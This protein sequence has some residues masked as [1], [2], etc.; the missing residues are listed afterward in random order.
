MSR[1]PIDHNL[2]HEK[3]PGLLNESTGENFGLKMRARPESALPLGG[4]RVVNGEKLIDAG[5]GDQIRMITPISDLL[6]NLIAQ[7]QLKKDVLN[8]ALA[9][10]YRLTDSPEREGVSAE[11]QVAKAVS[12][13]F[14]AILALQLSRGNAEE[15][16]GMLK[17]FST[18]SQN[19]ALGSDLQHLAPEVIKYLK[20]RGK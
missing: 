19:G 18:F 10:A 7:G 14:L 9:D 11:T 13:R 6:N 1:E 12:E 15:A 3:V 17:R 16:S 8:N 4:S 20:V 5:V 2:A